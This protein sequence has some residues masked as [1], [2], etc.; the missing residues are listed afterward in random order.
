LDAIRLACGRLLVALGRR[1]LRVVLAARRRRGAIR[2]RLW[3][4]LLVV[5]PGRR[6]L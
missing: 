6:R 3:R 4:G 2:V 1:L 5:S